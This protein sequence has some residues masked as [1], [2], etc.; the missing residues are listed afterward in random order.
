MLHETKSDTS[1]SIRQLLLGLLAFF[2]IMHIVSV[3]LMSNAHGSWLAFAPK[4]DL[5]N[6]FNAPTV[7]SGILWGVI[8]FMT[9]LLFSRS[10]ARIERLGWLFLSFFFFYLSFDEQMMIHEGVAEPIRKA[11]SISQD[12]IF[13]HAWV[14]P[15]IAV[16]LII[17]GLFVVIKGASRTTVV[18]KQVYKYVVVLG[19]G[20][21]ILEAL[22]TLIYFSPVIYKLGPVLFEEMFEMSM[23]SYILYRLYQI[24]FPSIK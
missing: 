24:V 7:Y 14:L 11:L 21:V 19:A 12:S 16:T 23:A 6:E 17:G 13:Y 18:Q 5:D 3:A 8:A 4:F 15:A 2:G 22:G 10:K 9:Y 20:I 1:R